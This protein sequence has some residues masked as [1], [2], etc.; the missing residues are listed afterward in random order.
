MFKHTLKI[1]RGSVWL[2]TQ[3]DHLIADVIDFGI[4]DSGVRRQ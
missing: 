3:S 4:F 1:M 2:L